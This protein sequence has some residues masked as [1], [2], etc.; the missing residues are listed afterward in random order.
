MGTQVH[1]CVL[2][3][4]SDSKC[5]AEHEHMLVYMRRYGHL[6]PPNA[7]L[8]RESREYFRAKIRQKSLFDRSIVVAGA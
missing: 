7:A 2:F 1:G 4:Y 5:R 3:G 6:K 8:E